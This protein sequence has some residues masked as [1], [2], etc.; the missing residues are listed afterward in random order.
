MIQIQYTSSSD[1]QWKFP[2]VAQLSKAIMAGQHAG[3]AD[4]SA[5]AGI[6]SGTSAGLSELSRVNTSINVYMQKDETLLI[7]RKDTAHIPDLLRP[8]GTAQAL[9]IVPYPSE[10]GDNPSP[11]AMQEILEKQIFNSYWNGVVLGYPEHFIDSY[12]RSFHTSLTPDKIEGQKNLA[13]IKVNEY[14][15]T[16]GLKKT[17]IALGSGPNILTDSLLDYLSEFSN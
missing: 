4:T 7:S 6:P 9:H 3:A 1:H 15:R 2:L 5:S 14:F 17:P 13:K 11:N 10:A 16:H 8:K 12:C